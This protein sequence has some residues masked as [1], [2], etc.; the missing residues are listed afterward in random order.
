MTKNLPFDSDFRQWSHP[1]MIP[2]H[3]LWDKSNN[4]TRCQ[5]ECECKFVFVLILFIHMHGAIVVP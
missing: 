3:C 2:M 1:L 4:R 5:F